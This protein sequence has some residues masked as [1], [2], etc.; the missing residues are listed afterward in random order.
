M[1]GAQPMSH[2]AIHSI[3]DLE[4]RLMG[5]GGWVEENK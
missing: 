5:K 3:K 4:L 1:C 2:D